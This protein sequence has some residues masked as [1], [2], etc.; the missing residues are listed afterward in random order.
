MIHMSLS[1][2]FRQAKFARID[3]CER[4]I[5]GFLLLKQLKILYEDVNLSLKGILKNPGLMIHMSRSTD[6]E[7]GPN[8]QGYDFCKR[9]V[10]WLFWA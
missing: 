8:S 2:D 6:F 7:L 5:S 1:F 3:F 9:M 4:Y 10:G